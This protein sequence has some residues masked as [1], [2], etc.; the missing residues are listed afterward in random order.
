MY[1]KV[2]KVEELDTKSD[3]VCVGVQCSP[4]E[5]EPLWSEQKRPRKGGEGD[6]AWKVKGVFFL[7]AFTRSRGLMKM[8]RKN[9]GGLGST[10]DN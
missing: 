7:V 10:E 4:V 2:L 9:E 6:Q 1:Y 8:R 5:N 3:Y